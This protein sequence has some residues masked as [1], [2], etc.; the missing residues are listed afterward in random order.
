M[1]AKRQ[2]QMKALSQK[3]LLYR[4]VQDEIKSYIIQNALEPGDSLPSEVELAQQLEVSR[5]SVREAVKALETLEIVEARSGAGLFVG[6]FSFDSLLDN[7]GYGILFH[8]KEL[9]DILEVRF[10]VEYGMVERAIEAVTPEQIE[11]LD[12]ILEDMRA[13]VEQGNYEAENDRLFHQILWA[14]VDNQVVQKILDVFWGIF[15]QARERAFIPEPVDLMK[16]YQRHVRILDA[17][18]KEDVA[19]LQESMVF[20][21]EGIKERLKGMQYKSPNPNLDKPDPKRK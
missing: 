5:N 10:H 3:P 1:A 16:T 19:A 8:M 4:L 6:N 14:N 11:R 12:E 9:A 13:L 7:L 18:K 20:H 2:F 17:L 21:Y 15:W